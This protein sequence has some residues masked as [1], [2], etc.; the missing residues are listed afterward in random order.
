MQNNTLGLD[1]FASRAI[2]KDFVAGKLEFR[3]SQVPQQVF[4]TTDF[5]VTHCQNA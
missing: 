5:T 1:V 2:Y 3:A 4:Q